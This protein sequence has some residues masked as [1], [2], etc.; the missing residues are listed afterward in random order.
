MA[1]PSVEQRIERELSKRGA[2]SFLDLK[3]AVKLSRGDIQ[4]NA[5]RLAH[6]G[7]VKIKKDAD[8]KHTY[9]TWA[10]PKEEAP[11]GKNLPARA[12]ASDVA[13]PRASRAKKFS[14][15]LPADWKQCLERSISSWS[16]HPTEKELMLQLL[17][18][19][20]VEEAANFIWSASRKVKPKWDASVFLE[21][22]QE[23][24]FNL[25]A[26]A[27]HPHLTVKDLR[28]RAEALEMIR[29]DELFRKGQAREELERSIAIVRHRKENASRTKPK[30]LGKRG[31][32]QFLRQYFQKY[33][34]KSLAPTTALLISAAFKVKWTASTVRARVSERANYGLKKATA[35]NTT[36]KAFAAL[37]KLNGVELEAAFEKMSPRLQ[38]LYLQSGRD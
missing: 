28:T 33:L 2:C 3:S 14:E 25:A 36:K 38:D 4:A 20:K 1:S 26:C 15:P 29:D 18:N 30:D 10:G 37:D 35:A 5:E 7:L 22:F 34:R 8:R 9:Y 24:L 12:S 32:L 31:A 27:G 23:V 11:V 16:H 6:R 13:S 19:E 21:R 17:Q